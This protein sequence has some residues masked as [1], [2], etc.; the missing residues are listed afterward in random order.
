MVNS[1][2]GFPK[3]VLENIIRC[4]P[5]N[6]ESLVRVALTCKTL[7][8]WV[9]HL[10]RSDYFWLE[11]LES[12]EAIDRKCHVF[13]YAVGASIVHAYACVTKRMI[14]VC[15]RLGTYLSRCTQNRG[16]P[17]IWKII[18]LK[19]ARVW[20]C[21]CGNI[22]GPTLEPLSS[23]WIVLKQTEC[24]V[25]VDRWFN[26]R[27][28]RESWRFNMRDIE[29]DKVKV[30]QCKCGRIARRVE[31]PAYDGT[32]VPFCV[33]GSKL[34]KKWSSLS[35]SGGEVGFDIEHNCGSFKWKVSRE[36]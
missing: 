34:D 18:E 29:H 33:C 17:P 26:S 1:L 27:R 14:V 21:T 24:K 5:I 28:T 2:L 6:D 19:N 12:Q 20:S 22:C 7:Y 13:F 25:C 31:F 32:V 11:K 10:L 36:D 35:G 30:V 3:E 15:P 8:T 23:C 4:L 16:M 9:T